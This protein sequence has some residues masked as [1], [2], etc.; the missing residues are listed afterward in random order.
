V[1]LSPDICYR[2]IRSKDARFDGRFFT[3]VTTTGVYCRPVCPARV[4]SR[5][6]VRFFPSAAAAEAAGFRPCLRCRPEASPGTPA[7]LG[8]SAT[9]SRALRHIAAGALDD[10]GVA[11][12]ASRMGVGERHLRRLFIDSLGAPPLAIAQTRRVQI[13][14]KLIDET[15]LPMAHIAFDA[16]FASVRRFNAALRRAYGRSPSELRGRTARPRAAAPLAL[17]LAFR[18]PLDWPALVGYL[19]PRAIPGVE[20]V[21]GHVYRR[22]VQLDGITAPI[23]VAPAPGRNELEVRVPP[24]LL[25]R[26]V[27]IVER[28][29]RLFD[30]GAEPR[31]ILGRLRRDRAL[32][33][34]LGRRQ[35]V[36]V[37]GAWD[38][39]ETAVR[40]VLGQQISVRAATTIAGRLARAYGAPLHSP[41]G[42]LTHA[43]P[44]PDAIAAAGLDGIGLTS[45]RRESLR[46]MAREVAEGRLSLEPGARPGASL[47]RLRAIRGIGEWTC[48][49]VALRALGEPDAFPAGDL[50]LRKAFA[51][52]DR[53]PTEAELVKR[54]EA[55]R[56]WRAYAA[57]LIWTT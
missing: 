25:R 47:E 53:L 32:A 29:R 52:G 20:E 57:L 27:T 46:A 39:F 28:V 31:E 4:P 22:V 23:E 15:S 21:T 56:P 40:A 50:G 13:A 17:R 26:V 18:P 7:W 9:V 10:D 42:G 8:T 2:A 55:W 36:R 24:E 41:R 6:N 35:D 43:F 34:R 54:A 30:L 5:G 1:T 16:G 11:T 45:A 33:A 38:G 37:P 19:A 12:L 3:G 51:R 14:K 48:Q 49:Y 44:A